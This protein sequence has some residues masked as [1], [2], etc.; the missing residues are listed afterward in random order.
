[1]QASQ[2]AARAARSQRERTQSVRPSSRSQERRSRPTHAKIFLSPNKHTPS[3]P[4]LPTKKRP[5]LF[6]SFSGMRIHFLQIELNALLAELHLLKADICVLCETKWHD[7]FRTPPPTPGFRLFCKN[8][9]TETERSRQKGVAILVKSE[10]LAHEV[11]LKTTFES[12]WV[13]VRPHDHSEVTLGSIYV[14]PAKPKQLRSLV[15]IIDKLPT[16]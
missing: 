8:F 16:N 12:I 2:A 15:P 5:V 9:N 7:V 13:T 4:S 3:T 10:L 14:D 1:M 11:S 6:E